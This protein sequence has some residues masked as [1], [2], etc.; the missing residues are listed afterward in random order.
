MRIVLILLSSLFTLSAYGQEWVLRGSGTF[1]TYNMAGMEQLQ[2]EF[3]ASVQPI[4]AKKVT[5][6][7]GWVGFDV[8]GSRLNGNLEWSSYFSYNA[9]GGRVHYAD[10]SGEVKLD[11]KLRCTTIGGGFTGKINEWGNHQ[12]RIGL[13]LG[14][15]VTEMKLD[16]IVEI[17]NQIVESENVLFKSLNVHTTILFRYEYTLKNFIFFAD[18]GYLIAPV[19]GAFTINGDGEVYIQLNTGEKLRAEW[20]GARVAFGIGYKFQN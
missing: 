6:F 15:A 4:A 13:R 20:G 16:N 7:P 1:G 8:E 11:Q 14:L 9:T 12:L 3:V 19:K 2:D 17:Q 10:Y 5:S 18:A